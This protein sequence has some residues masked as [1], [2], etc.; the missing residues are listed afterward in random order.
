MIFNGDGNQTSVFTD[1]ADATQLSSPTLYTY[2]DLSLL[3]SIESASYA[4]QTDGTVETSKQRWEF[5]YDGMS[6]LRVSRPFVWDAATG[7]WVIVFGRTSFEK[8]RVYDGMDV[9]QERKTDNA[10]RGTVTRAG[11]IGGILAR[12]RYG[13]LMRAPIT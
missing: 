11:N 5:V 1:P 8:R 10:V 6:R 3:V 9:V 12:T 4:R 7:T 2:D 13:S